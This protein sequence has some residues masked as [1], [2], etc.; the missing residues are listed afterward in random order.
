MFAVDALDGLRRAQ[1]IHVMKCMHELG[2][3][4]VSTVKPLDKTQVARYLCGCRA[5]LAMREG[6]GQSNDEDIRKGLID[7]TVDAQLDELSVPDA[8]FEAMRVLVDT[9]LSDLATA[10]SAEDYEEIIREELA[11]DA[12]HGDDEDAAEDMIVDYSD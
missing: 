5:E 1:P 2:A 8:Q 9:I 6:Q 10:K 4:D 3:R 7:K 12:E 11:Y